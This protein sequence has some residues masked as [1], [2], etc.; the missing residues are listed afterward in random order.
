M[1]RN[2]VDAVS[3]DSLAMLTVAIEASKLPS[4]TN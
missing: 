1:S 3:S 2:S 4:V